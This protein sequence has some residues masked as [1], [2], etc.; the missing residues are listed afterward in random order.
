MRFS[1]NCFDN[2]VHIIGRC[3]CICNT[4]LVKY[5]FKSG[6]TLAPF[7]FIFVLFEHTITEK[8]VGFSGIRTRIIGVEGEHHGPYIQISYAGLYLGR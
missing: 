2:K 8:T 5:K 4:Y 6:Q 7:L 3:L 1:S